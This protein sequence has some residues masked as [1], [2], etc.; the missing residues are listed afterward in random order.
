M[1]TAHYELMIPHCQKSITQ[2]TITAPF[3]G[4]AIATVDT[5]DEAAAEQALVNA[6]ACWDNREQW[7]TLET[8]LS[9]LERLK[10]AVLQQQEELALLAAREGGKPLHDSRI[11]V[12]RGADGIQWCMDH[13]RSHG[14]HVIPMKYN[15]ASSHRIAFTQ[16]EPIGIVL[17][18][19]AFN[20]PFNLIIHQVVTAVAAGCPIIVK[21]ATD[22]PLSCLRIVQLLR[23]A[24]LPEEWCQ[25]L[26][27]K[28]IA[29][30]TKVVRDKRLAFF[31][32]IGSGKV[33]WALRRELA[34]GVRCALEHGGVAP[35]IVCADADVDLALP[36]LCK[37]GFYHAGQVCVSV[38]RVFA[39]QTIARPVAEGLAALAKVLQVGDPTKETTEVGP[40]I[41][42]SEVE[43]VHE[44]VKEAVVHGAQ[45]LCGGEPLSA[46][47]YAPTVLYNPPPDVA[48]SCK[49]V[50]GPV[51]CV[52]PFEH[53]EN[54]IAQANDLPV[55]FQ[56]AV[57]TQDIDTAMTVYQQ[58]AASAVMI[59]DH[60]AF[61]VDA[62]PFAGLRES[63]LGVGG[64]PYTLADL[65][66]DKLCVIHSPGL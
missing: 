35:A 52:Y 31:S 30:A 57:F 17:A 40:L 54:A 27:V 46:T 16:K 38:Q 29:I 22:T 63:G 43:R 4:V 55:A 19:S 13:C 56:S 8:R 50:F 24:G 39:Q 62:M 58:S 33:G 28:D 12:A 53:L 6:K 48:V 21:P 51:V 7:L 25:V 42:P 18:I 3:D 65:Q 5:A 49:E 10:A 44:W 61:R 1:M 2:R 26:I 20:H 9:I 37:G 45:L 64:I 66:I 15:G 59:N 36:L 60:T 14:G 11:E 47:M 41:R 34:P 32:F 23:E